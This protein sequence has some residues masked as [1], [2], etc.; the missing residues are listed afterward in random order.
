MFILVTEVAFDL[1]LLLP[2]FGNRSTV[3]IYG[4]GRSK[5]PK[6]PPDRRI[7]S[8]LEV[9]ILF[10]GRAMEE[11]CSQL[12]LQK[13]PVIVL[14]TLRLRFPFRHFPLRPLLFYSSYR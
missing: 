9:V 3:R 1:L 5:S 14:L 2:L 7:C 12:S 8:V 11:M 13:G 4:E 6:W 10:Y